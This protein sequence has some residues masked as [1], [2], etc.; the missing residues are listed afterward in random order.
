MNYIQ[1]EECK[2][3]HH[4]IQKLNRES[5]NVDL[6]QSVILD[7]PALRS[8]IDSCSLSNLSHSENIEKEEK[9]Q[10]DTQNDDEEYIKVNN[11]ENVIQQYFA[12]QDWYLVIT[13]DADLLDIK[14]VI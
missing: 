13:R 12:D 3:E 6:S 9:Y 10:K 8:S 4:E 11:Q 14:V 2:I 7:V 1:I 5:E